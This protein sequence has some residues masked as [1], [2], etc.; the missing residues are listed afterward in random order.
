MLN[1]EVRITVERRAYIYE[2]VPTSKS[3][4]VVMTCSETAIWSTFAAIILF[5]GVRYPR[6]YRFT[7][8]WSQN[9]SRNNFAIS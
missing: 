4:Q 6:K 5:H 9:L 8:F 1:R 7:R 2:L 3:N